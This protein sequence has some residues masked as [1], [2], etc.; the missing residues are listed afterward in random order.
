[1]G[2]LLVVGRHDTGDDGDCVL[3]SSAST[4]RAA[5]SEWKP[6]SKIMREIVFVRPRLCQA[7]AVRQSRNLTVLQRLP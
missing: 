2:R 4:T 1:M 7:G 3:Y 5:A 6:P